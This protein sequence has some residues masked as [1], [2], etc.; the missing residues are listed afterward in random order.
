MREDR[1]S[2]RA[3]G[4]KANS[5]RVSRL[6]ARRAEGP[7]PTRIRTWT[8]RVCLPGAKANVAK[9]S[10]VEAI[11]VTMERLLSKYWDRMVT[12][13]RKLKQNP[14]PEREPERTVSITYD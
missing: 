10:P 9:H 4:K 13:G 5:G 12:V 6:L 3:A 2:N 1:S 8:T 7:S 11:A 14:K